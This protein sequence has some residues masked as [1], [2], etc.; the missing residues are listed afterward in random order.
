MILNISKVEMAV[1]VVHM[2]AMR[3]NVRKGFKSNYGRKEGKEVLASYDEVKLAFQQAIE[4]L[5]DDSQAVDLHF[6]IKEVNMLHSFVSW[7]A[8]ELELTFEAAGKQAGE[9][10]QKQIDTFNEIKNRIEK[11]LEDYAA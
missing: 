8:A 2:S 1:L 6:N 10:D 3:Q 5:E 4:G 9:E 7:Y 11:V